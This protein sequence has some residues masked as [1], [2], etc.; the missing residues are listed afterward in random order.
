LS[1]L[2]TSV[3]STFSRS[4]P[5]ETLREGAIATVTF[6]GGFMLP[7]IQA[8]ALLTNDSPLM[9]QAFG[10][11]SSPCLGNWKLLKVLDRFALDRSIH[12]GGW[13]FFFMA[14]EVKGMFL[15]APGEKKIQNALQ[16]MLE[17]VK[18]Q[19][20][21]GLEVTGI[22]AKRFLGVPYAVVTAHSRHL[23]RSCYLD[24]A[25]TRGLSRHNAE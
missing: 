14:A 10:L 18:Q 12:A 24:S 6:F 3:A 21:N 9:M 15:G 1:G 13:N 16:R 4:D 2:S 22:V 19:R 8:G 25:E 17:R 11:E 20:F 5:I 7:A 23:Q